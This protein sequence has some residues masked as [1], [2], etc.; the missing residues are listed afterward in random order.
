MIPTSANIQFSDGSKSAVS[1]WAVEDVYDAAES[2]IR[3]RKSYKLS[4]ADEGHE[5]AAKTIHEVGGKTEFERYTQRQIIAWLKSHER[6]GLKRVLLIGDSIRMRQSSST[7]YCRPAYRRMLGK[8]NLSH[9]PHNCGGSLAVVHNLPDWLSCEPDFVHINA[10]LHDLAYY[11][12]GAQ[13]D[14][15]ASASLDDYRKNL[16]EIFN[17]LQDR[18]IE[19]IW[20]PN[21]PVDD[22]WHCSG[23]RLLH[24]RNAT[25]IAYNDVAKDVAGEFRIPINDIYTPLVD[26]GIRNTI[27]SDGVH[28]SHT[29][30]AT[31]GKHVAEAVLSAL[32]IA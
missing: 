23:E 18:S 13:A 26:A 24:R 16:R 20:A 5:V 10:G 25:V 21:T 9:I 28:L 6:P 31:A 1:A 8:V 4:A 27:V 30:S 15:V 7:G 29:G 12:H 2:V 17:T 19:V 14:H 22:E 11:P 3:R 32:K